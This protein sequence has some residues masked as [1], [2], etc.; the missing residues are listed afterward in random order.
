MFTSI[1]IYIYVMLKAL[2]YESLNNIMDLGDLRMNGFNV[3]YPTLLHAIRTSHHN[4][5]MWSYTLALFEKL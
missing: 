5:T 1:V 2:Q 3:I 4:C